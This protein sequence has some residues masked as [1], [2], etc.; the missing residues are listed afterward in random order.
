[1]LELMD[2]E[3]FSSNNVEALL[4]KILHHLKVITHCEAGTIY[5]KKDNYLT[6]SIFQNESFSSQKVSSLDRSI[7]FSIKQDTNILAVESYL[8][9]KIITVDDI[10]KD[11]SYDF[12]A[13]KEFDI[14][15]DYKTTSVLTAPLID[16]VN[17]ETVGIIQL[18]NKKVDEEYI[19]FTH[20]DQEFISLSS[21]FIVLSILNAKNNQAELQRQNNELEKKIK[22][23]TK[24]LLDIQV[25]LQEQAHRDPLTNL[26]NR[27]HFNEVSESLFSISKRSNNPLSILMIDIDNFKAIND[28]YGHT[29]GDLVIQ[30][31]SD[32]LTN[33]IR[34]SDIAIRYGGEEFLLLLTNTS[35]QNA[36]VIAE[37][38]RH[39]VQNTT[40]Y[41]KESN[42]L[43]FTISLGLAIVDKED[44]NISIAINK[45]DQALYKAKKTGKNKTI[46]LS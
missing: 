29:I 5:L 35:I 30:T 4:H 45:A 2:I 33:T 25:K 38:L 15:Y 9:S 39:H 32:I 42:D 31:L 12:K 19:P 43:E 28:N 23:R 10:Y 36:N 1:M 44:E 18:I 20:E 16:T 14:K 46:S 37:K 41:S 34:S 22:Q 24:E 8:Q 27:R 13:T 7:K 26:H 6:F 11:T 40:I 3:D 17:H 21:Y